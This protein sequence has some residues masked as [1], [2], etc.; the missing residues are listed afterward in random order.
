MSASAPA[1]IGTWHNS[2][3]NTFWFNPTGCITRTGLGGDGVSG[4][5]GWFDRMTINASRSSSIYGSS[6]TIRPI[7][8]EVRFMLRY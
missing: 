2:T 6:N 8:K 4:N 5:A 1:I 7:S 3:E